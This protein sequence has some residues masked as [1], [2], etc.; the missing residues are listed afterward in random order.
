MQRQ[1]NQAREDVRWLIMHSGITG[2]VTRPATTGEDSFYGTHEPQESPVG[3][4]PVELQYLPPK[5]L[6]ELGAD[7]VASVLPDSGV[8]EQDFI[9]IAGT[10]YRV[11]EVK[12]HNFFG[13]VTHLN[14]HLERERRDG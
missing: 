5:D 4:I 7:A 10:R 2:A 8:L 1:R 9:E 12:P 14:L 3:T 13:T 11:T 6:T